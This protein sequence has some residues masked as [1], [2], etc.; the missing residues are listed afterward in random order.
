M[1]SLASGTKTEIACVWV[2]VAAVKSSVQQACM[3][4]LLCAI[5]SEYRAPRVPKCRGQGQPNISQENPYGS[6]NVV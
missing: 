1:L 2:R 5:A 6:P 3:G 4:H